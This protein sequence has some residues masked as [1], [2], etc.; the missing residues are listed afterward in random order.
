MANNVNAAPGRPVPK[1][2]R[3]ARQYLLGAL[4]LIYLGC[5]WRYTESLLMLVN[6]EIMS[7]W[8][9]LLMVTGTACLVLGVARSLYDARLGVYCLLSAAV[10]FAIAAPQIGNWQYKLSQSMLATLVLGVCI[11]LF[12]AWLARRAE[13]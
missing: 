8:A 6:M 1:P 10:E 5:A 2:K 13:R 11:A 9:G 4:L 3:G 12:G 7:Q